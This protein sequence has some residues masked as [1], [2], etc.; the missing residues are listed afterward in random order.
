MRQRKRAPR[1]VS[2]SL[3]RITQPW[4]QRG[5]PLGPV[6]IAGSLLPPSS[7]PAAVKAISRSPL[8][9]SIS[10]SSGRGQG[11]LPYTAAGMGQIP[12]GFSSLQLLSVERFMASQ[13]SVAGTLTAIWVPKSLFLS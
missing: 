7:R 6:K 8:I 4:G 2:L 11:S 1:P 5:W 9:G 12:S 10:V 3:S 13:R